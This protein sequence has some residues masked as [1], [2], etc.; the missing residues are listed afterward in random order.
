LLTLITFPQT[1]LPGD[2][3]TRTP[4][5]RK[6][7]SQLLDEI[8]RATTGQKRS[9]E[10]TLVRLDRRQRA[11]VDVRAVV[12]P[13]LKRQVAG[14][15]GTIVSTAPEVDSLIAWIPLMKLEQLAGNSSIRSIQPAATAAHK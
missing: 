7:D 11:L 2:K 6:I 8:R 14:L 9:A 12:T 3:S 4:A 15:G 5:Q 13:E 10:A 1:A